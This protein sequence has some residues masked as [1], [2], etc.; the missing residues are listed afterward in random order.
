M[1]LYCL[2]FQWAGDPC[3][4]KDNNL[5]NSNKIILCNFISIRIL[6][7][8]STRK[9]ILKLVEIIKHLL[10]DLVKSQSRI[11]SGLVNPVAQWCHQWLNFF[12]CLCSAL[13]EVPHQGRS[14][15]QKL[16]ME[17]W[18]ALLCQVSPM[19][20][21]SFSFE[22]FKPMSFPA[23]MI[24]NI[25]PICFIYSFPPLSTFFFLLD[26]VRPNITYFTHVVTK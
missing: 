26:Y 16:E 10:L 24:I 18:C 2:V 3:L 8:A 12:P 23:L 11:V 22:N 1:L 15:N 5:K 13:E 19:S 17:R 9:P 25:L 14:N 21:K 6:L 4:I 20:L 7:A